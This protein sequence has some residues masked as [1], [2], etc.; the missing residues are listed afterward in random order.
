MD[1]IKQRRANLGRS[2]TTDIHLL[3]YVFLP[4]PTSVA[5][6]WGYLFSWYSTHLILCPIWLIKRWFLYPF[7]FSFFF[8]SVLSSKIASSKKHINLVESENWLRRPVPNMIAR[9]SV[10]SLIVLGSDNPFLLYFNILSDSLMDSYW[11]RQSQLNQ[12][13]NISFKI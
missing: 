6:G 12:S 3:L 1:W 2:V 7:F 9:P 11:T 10:R 5:T 4:S 8:S 13:I